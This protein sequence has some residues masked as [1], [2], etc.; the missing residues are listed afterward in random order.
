MLST[1]RKY[2]PE[3]DGLRCLAVM[4]VIAYHAGLPF[5]N[6]GYAG[7][8]VFFVI[9]G[10]LITSILIGDLEHGRFSIA[11]FYEN[12]A[13]R[14]LPALLAVILACIPFSWFWMTPDQFQAFAKS[15]ISVN[16]FIS[17]HYFWSETG[18]FDSATELNPLIHTWSLAIEEQFYLFLP[19]LLWLV[20]RLGRHPTM[21]VI[22]G[23]T[24]ASFSLCLFGITRKPDMT[25]F[26]LPFRAW[27]LGAGALCAFSTIGEKRG[28]QN[29]F[30]WLGLVM[31]LASMAVFNHETPWPSQATLL[32]VVGTALIILF[33][34][35][36][37]GAGAIL[38]SRPFVAIGLISYSAYLW[39]QPLFAYARI[40]SLSE[41][42]TGLMVVLGAL[43]LA[44]AALSW[45]FIEQPFRNK[46][47]P[48]PPRRRQVFVFSATG[49]FL[50]VSIG[51]LILWDEGVPNRISK[52]QL[53]F[54]ER[55]ELNSSCYST[56]TRDLSNHPKKACLSGPL[57]KPSV[58]IAGDSHAAP[59]AQILQDPL[60]G[61]GVTSYAWSFVGCVPIPSL[62]ARVFEKHT[63]CVEYNN[64]LRS[65]LD[66]L[67][68]PVLVLSGRWQT[69]LREEAFDNGEGGIEKGRS[70]TVDVVK[71]SGAS[72]VD[73]E[74]ERAVLTAYREELLSLLERYRVLLVYPVPEAGWNV[75]LL[76]FKK[77]RFTNQSSSDI[78]TDSIAFQNR[79][80]DVV[81]LFDGIQH[82]NLYRIRPHEVLCDS[83][84]SSRC[85]NQL[86]GD[87]LYSDD[88]H[89][90]PAGAALLLP[91]LLEQLDTALNYH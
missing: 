2:R 16:L 61:K 60:A 67:D 6:G 22:A 77:A 82:P 53:A 40:R 56:N 55:H 29:L 43:T 59:I 69:Y 48:F 36:E 14:I 46:N 58:V 25:F 45:R 39:H 9:S 76:A 8:D 11:R 64:R 18:Y 79:S 27:E 73:I 68:N 37:S 88:D 51:G 32:P 91:F 23:L 81:E 3:I 71:N 89:L 86:D 4:P 26:L 20:W 30:G 87:L 31:V 24:L 54:L 21:W 28:L 85:M 75:P 1:D 41:P 35:K 74:R 78:S 63:G 10:Y 66:T 19:V 57:N 47:R 50:L 84:Q 83:F 5:L 38:S 12:R 52:E 17:N 72:Q 33:C 42:S 62:H 80:R 13:R 15:I 34:Q 90:S 44:L 49:M 65:Y 7:V 70:F